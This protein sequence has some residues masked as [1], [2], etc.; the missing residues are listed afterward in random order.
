VR[1][2][3][4]GE[5]TRDGFPY[6]SVQKFAPKVVTDVSVGYDITKKVNFFVLNIS[7]TLN[8]KS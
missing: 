7:S 8:P 2:T 5:V 4:F 6:G 1:N 3:Y